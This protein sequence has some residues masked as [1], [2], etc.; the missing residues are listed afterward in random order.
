MYL[1]WLYDKLLCDIML[2]FVIQEMKFSEV[3]QC[4]C[5]YLFFNLDFRWSL[6]PPHENGFN[7]YTQSIGLAEI[8]ET[9]FAEVALTKVSLLY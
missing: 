1:N 7:D 3:K 8:R 5:S 9:M 4:F 2:S 6:K